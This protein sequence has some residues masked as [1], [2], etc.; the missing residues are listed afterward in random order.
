MDRLRP[1]L[2]FGFFFFTSRFSIFVNMS[3]NMDSELNEEDYNDARAAIKTLYENIV[4]SHT[5][6][7]NVRLLLFQSVLRFIV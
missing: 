6:T 2:L 5:K 4:R 7:V 1:L 3:N